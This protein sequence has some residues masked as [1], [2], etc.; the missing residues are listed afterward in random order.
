MRQHWKIV[1]PDT[2]IQYTAYCVCTQHLSMSLFLSLSLARTQARIQAR[3]HA[4]SEKGRD[5]YTFFVYGEWDVVDRLQ[6]HAGIGQHLQF[7]GS[8][9]ETLQTWKKVHGLTLSQRSGV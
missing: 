6:F 5:R 1:W 3:T 7:H 9:R 2:G 4:H 8:Q